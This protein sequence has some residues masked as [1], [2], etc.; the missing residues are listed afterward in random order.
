MDLDDIEKE[1]FRLRPEL[2]QLLVSITKNQDLAEDLLQDTIMQ[3]LSSYNKG[4]EIHF[5]TFKN[6]LITIAYSRARDHFR[7]S[8]RKLEVS[9]EDLPENWE[10]GS[11]DRP[12]CSELIFKIINNLLIDESIPLRVREVLKFRLIDKIKIE[13]ICDY[14]SVSRQTVHRDYQAGMELL[15]LEFEK[16]HLTPEDIR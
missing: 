6:Y 13:D 2:Y 12:D 15:R 14:L 3:I 4:Q 16:N 5:E 9:T 7:R 1:Y 10:E 11:E 8:Y